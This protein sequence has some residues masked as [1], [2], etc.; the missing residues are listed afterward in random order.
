MVTP[1]PEDFH[2]LQEVG[3]DY[4]TI[5][6]APIGAQALHGVC[7]DKRSERCPTAYQGQPRILPGSTQ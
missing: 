2:V 5:I 1:R 6:S 3:H 7:R 4:G